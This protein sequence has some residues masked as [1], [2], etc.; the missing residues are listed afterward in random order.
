MRAGLPG[1]AEARPHM[2]PR[3]LA[4]IHL[5]RPESRQELRAFIASFLA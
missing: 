2:P 1:S 4:K 5:T 3:A